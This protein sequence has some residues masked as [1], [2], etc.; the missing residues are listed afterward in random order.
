MSPRCSRPYA[1]EDVHQALADFDGDS[2]E[3]RI[4]RGLHC[5]NRIDACDLDAPVRGFPN[6]NVAGQED[7]KLV[8]HLEPFM[9]ELGVACAEDP[10]A[11]QLRSDLRLQRST[12]VDIGEHSETL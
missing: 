3:S 8:L 9:C 1:L 10:I 4:A 11:R 2:G 12:D 6:N 5:C 7:A